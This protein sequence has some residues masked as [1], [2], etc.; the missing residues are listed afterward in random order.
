[1]LTLREAQN[2]HNTCPQYMIHQ[3]SLQNTVGTRIWHHL[4][5]LLPHHQHVLQTSHR[6]KEAG[7]IVILHTDVGGGHTGDTTILDQVCT[8]LHLARVRHIQMRSS[9]EQAPITFPTYSTPTNPPM[10]PS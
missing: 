10:Y 8:T 9:S 5:L 6:C 2:K 7:P 4:Q 3:R 1:M